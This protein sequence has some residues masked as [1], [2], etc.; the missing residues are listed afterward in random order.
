M[1]RHQVGYKTAAAPSLHRLC[2]RRLRAGA[3]QA[4]SGACVHCVYN[5]GFTTRGTMM[6]HMEPI[7][8]KSGPREA[9]TGT[10]GQ[11]CY[12]G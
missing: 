4:C 7:I 12:H 8:W 5:E 1:C 2:S 10:T 6:A 9:E 11:A 3:N